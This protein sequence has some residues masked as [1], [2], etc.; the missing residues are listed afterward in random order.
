MYFACIRTLLSDKSGLRFNICRIEEPTLSEDIHDLDERL[1]ASVSEML[2]YSSLFWFTHLQYS[3]LDRNS[4]RESV[5]E[6]LCTVKLIFWL[7]LSTLKG[8]LKRFTQALE[9]CASF[10][11]V[12]RIIRPKN[13]RY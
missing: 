10:F 3:G 8:T 6:L 13:R 2:G 7:E 11:K 12:G 1:L 5:R 4:T 9:G